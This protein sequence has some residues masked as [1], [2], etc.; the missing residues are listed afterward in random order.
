[1]SSHPQQVEQAAKLLKAAVLL[2]LV[3]AAGLSAAPVPPQGRQSLPSA[4]KVLGRYVEATGQR[5]LLRHQSMTVHGRYQVPARNLDLETV[6]YKKGGKLLQ[7]IVLPDGKEYLSG[8]D[9]QTAW[10]LAPSGKV[11]LHRGKE[12]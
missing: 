3:Y 10:D 8:Y 12:L 9:G 1:M 5:A 7:R 4:A 2:F 11:T 6:T